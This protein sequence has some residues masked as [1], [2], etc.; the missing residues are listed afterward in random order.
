MHINRLLFEIPCQNSLGENVLWHQT[1]QA[2][3]WTDIEG[4]TLFKCAISAEVM[5]M[6]SN[7][8][9][10]DRVVKAKA[11]YFE[12]VLQVF[13]LPF[14]LGSF[15]FT[16]RTHLLLAG[17]E[18]GLA[19]FDYTTGAIQWLSQQHVA[20]KHLRFNDG[21]CDP[22]GRFWLGS[23]VEN[24]DI[25]KLEV[26]DQA[27]LYTFSLANNTLQAST[28]LSGLH[29]SNGLC[30]SD[31]GRVM[32]HSD[33]STHKVYQYLLDDSGKIES[34][35]LFAKFDK[36][37][38]PDG[39]CTDIYGNIWVALWGGACV[40]CFDSKGNELYRHPLPVTQVTCV[41]IGGPNM[42]WLFVTSASANLSEDKRA[43]QPRAG[44]LFVYELT[45][46]IGVV[47]PHVAQ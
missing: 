40:V 18:N 33:S 25:K 9:I 2:V 42:N 13:D 16:E 39:A 24:I 19:L 41:S 45:A 10:D 21:K 38:Y 7:D 47:E 29:I 4:K 3:Y 27:A 35:K 11:D 30:F 15:A 26:E 23:M 43:K 46:S 37:I 17:F 12:E 8:A 6:L 32:Y 20:D 1:E 36:H 44:N 28:V 22:K 14:R 31:S 5:G 34:R